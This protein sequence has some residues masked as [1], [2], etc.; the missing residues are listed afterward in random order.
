MRSSNPQDGPA[1]FK[2]HMRHYHRS[3]PKPGRSWD[4]WVGGGPVHSGPSRDW[5]KILMIIVAIVLGVG[6][7][8]GLIIELR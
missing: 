2:G 7:V 6:I 5:L 4:E 8:A 1:R 3:G